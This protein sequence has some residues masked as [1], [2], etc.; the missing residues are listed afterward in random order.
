MTLSELDLYLAHGF[1]PYPDVWATLAAQGADRERAEDAWRRRLGDR[2]PSNI[3]AYR[4]AFGPPVEDRDGVYHWALTLWPDHEW[5]VAFYDWPSLGHNALLRQCD[6]ARRVPG[7]PERVSPLSISG[8]RRVLRPGYDTCAEVLAAL[9][10]AP[11]YDG[12]WP[13]DSWEYDLPDGS[14]LQCVFAH[15]VLVD[16][17]P[18]ALHDPI[19]RRNYTWLTDP[20]SSS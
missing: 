17:T 2:L 14:L 3:G 5:L 11:K 6:I 8:A 4:D 15:N 12:W 10:E 18:E 16:I 1:A 20:P 13:W 7:A 19:V 9:G